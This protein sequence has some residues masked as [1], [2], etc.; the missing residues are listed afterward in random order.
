MPS[1]SKIKKEIDKCA[2]NPL[3]FINN[4]CR[5][6]HPIKGLIPFSTFAFQDG[7]VKSFVANR[8]N[9]VLKARQLGI[10]TLTSA[11]VC[12]MMLF[13]RNRKI[14]VVA[15][16]Q[17]TAANLVLKVKKIYQ[18][19]PSFFK[20]LS[21]VEKNNE[22]HFELKNGS[23]IKAES[24]SSTAGRSEALSMLIIDEAAHVEKLGGP[25]GLWTGL[26]PTLSTGGRCIAI[27]TPNGVGNWFHEIC[28]GAES[29]TNN[30]KLTRLNW[31]VHPERDQEWFDE[32]TKDMERR[33]IAQELLCSFNASGDTLID[34]DDLDRIEKILQ[35]KDPDPSRAGRLIKEPTWRSFMDRNYWIWR[36]QIDGHTYVITADVARGDGR[37]Y[38]TAQVI[39]ATTNE[40]VAEYQGK[41]SYDMFANL[42]YSI[43]EDYGFPMMVIENNTI[44][45]TVI[46]ELQNMNYP[47]IYYADSKGE[48]ISSIDAEFNSSAKPGFNNSSRTRPLIVAKLEEYIRNK[49]I[50]IRS[51]RLYNEL[52]TF[53]WNGSK[54]E[55]I[56]GKNDDLVIAFAI[57]CWIRDTAL[58]EKV[59]E[60]Q[61]T[62]Q[63]LSSIYKQSK[64]WDASVQTSKDFSTGPYLNREKKSLMQKRE[65]YLKYS[66]LL[67]G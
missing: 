2:R 11:Y 62:E 61:Y 60:N 38:S 6:E 3:Y 41:L 57:A 63:M 66:A 21:G 32:E 28:M 35:A 27:S 4:Y 49:K 12:W 53:I 46:N 58:K 52:T 51:Y 29:G 7:V 5:I 10:S 65:E 13:R 47:N 64:V 54:V 17:G 50:N 8:F 43:G 67:K 34:P 23:W 36:Q 42:L 1:R 40:Q 15:T 24:T 20:A 25:N 16:K 30:F 18:H 37:D 22:S 31:D 55:A 26:K 33:A 45:L 9:V 59:R 39:D 56:T 19:L 44:G 48:Y 14:L